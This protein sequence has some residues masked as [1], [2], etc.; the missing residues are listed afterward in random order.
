MKDEL[1]RACGN[2][3]PEASVQEAVAAYSAPVRQ[4]LLSLP[5]N[6]IGGGPNGFNTEL[7]HLLRVGQACSAS[8][9]EVLLL[10]QLFTLTGGPVAFKT[11]PCYLDVD[12]RHG[13]GR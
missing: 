8:V 10:L 3:P 11:E 2:V 6:Q 9:R 4:V 12:V 7:S 5:V 1:I 13:I